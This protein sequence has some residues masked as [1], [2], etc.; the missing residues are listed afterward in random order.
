[1]VLITVA[2]F[3]AVMPPHVDQYLCFKLADGTVITGLIDTKVITIQEPNGNVQDIPVE[4]LGKLMVGFSDKP[5]LVKRVDAL[6]AALDSAE[7]RQDAQQELSDL[8]PAVTKI[9]KRHVTEEGSPRQE[10]FA[11]IFK[12]YDRWFSSHLREPQLLSEAIQPQSRIV[13]S[14]RSR[15]SEF[16]GTVKVKQFRITSPYG[17]VV[18]TLADLCEISRV[19][20]PA[21]GKF[22]RWA[23]ELRDRTHVRG[24]VSNKSFRVETPYGT[25][26]VPLSLIEEATFAADGNAIHVRC[27]EADRI[28]GT[29][30][31]ETTISLTTDNG[32][33]DLPVEKIAVARYG[34]ITLRASERGVL[35]VAFSPDS[36]RLASS[37]RDGIIRFWDVATGK[38]GLTF[39]VQNRWAG[40]SHVTS[41]AFSPDGKSLA[42]G[43]Q[44]GGGI[45]LW[46]TVT[47][48]VLLTL[49]R[50]GGR[51]MVSVVAFSPDG[52]RLASGGKGKSI[53]LWD[54]ATGKEL[55]ALKGHDRLWVTSVAFSPDG[56]RLASG[57]H[58]GDLKLWDA[59]TGKELFSLD[60]HG[61]VGCFVTFS[62]DGKYLASAIPGAPIKL[63]DP[64]TGKELLT[65]KTPNPYYTGRHLA[66]SPDG[67]RLAV[68]C[69]DTTIKL[70]DTVT[71]EELCLLGKS[72]PYLSCLVF[73]PDGKHLASGSEWVSSRDR[74]ENDTL[75][76]WD[77]RDWAMPTKPE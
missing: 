7:T 29:I 52:K 45:R 48:K 75:K 11:Q 4:D 19:E 70:W 20:P 13:A 25:V 53:Q 8:G 14:G 17:P 44:R 71:G 33:L 36:K 74:R 39:E 64:V 30:R 23:V 68:G 43:D 1:M 50:S 61:Q 24:T 27:W 5:E 42:S 54:T 63:L 28:D 32:M 76:L 58:S 59:V 41:I 67:K 47:G 60:V 26:A 56:K 38:D 6:V 72:S 77:A 34:P 31:P 62:P 12:I 57:N 49:R 2:V 69:N 3:Y 9:L 51:S 35:T 10:A 40:D 65:L 16:Y 22:G 18:V 15:R 55:L 46:D 66:F 21:L 73:S 37:G